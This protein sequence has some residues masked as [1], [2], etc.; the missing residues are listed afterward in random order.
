M[1]LTLTRTP[2][3]QILLQLKPGTSAAELHE[4]LQ[5]GIT[6]TLIE[7]RSAGARIKVDAPKCLAIS[8]P[9]EK[10]ERPED[11]PGQELVMAY[12]E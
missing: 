11:C 6:I 10:V 1:G 3:H 7:N 9:V 4:Q 2:G 5:A 8:R 12:P